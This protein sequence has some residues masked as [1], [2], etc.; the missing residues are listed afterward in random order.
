MEVNSQATASITDWSAIPKKINEIS[1]FVKRRPNELTEL[2]YGTVNYYS[3]VESSDVN[4]NVNHSKN[5]ADLCARNTMK[6][7]NP[8][9]GRRCRNFSLSTTCN[10]QM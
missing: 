3:A 10:D 1:C 2:T 7:L 9:G 6:T 5:P 4:K 8:L